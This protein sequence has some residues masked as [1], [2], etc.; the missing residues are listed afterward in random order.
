MGSS[1]SADVFYG[2]DLG[3]D[4]EARPVDYDA[5]DFDWDDVTE[6][7]SFDWED[8]LAAKLGWVEVPYPGSGFERSSPEY[9]AWSASLAQKRG[10]LASVGAEIDSYSYEGSAK[11]IRVTASVQHVSDWGSTPLKPL[12]VDPEWADQIA[13]FVELLELKVP[14]GGPGWHLNCSYG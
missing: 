13:R 7:A 1:P 3:D 8:E 5:E 2:Y 12:E 14:E 9:E 4:W 6:S 10:L 11:C